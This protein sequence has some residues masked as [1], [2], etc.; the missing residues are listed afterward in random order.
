MDSSVNE[1]KLWE[2]GL[3]RFLAE[4]KTYGDRIEDIWFYETF[5]IPYP[6]PQVP[7]GEAQK[8]KLAC[9][10]PRQRFIE[11]LLKRHQMLA[12]TQ[13]DGGYE[14]IQP[15]EQTQYAVDEGQRELKNATDKM[16]ARIK[17]IRLE[18]LDEIQRRENA[19]ARVRAD[20]LASMTKSVWPRRK[21]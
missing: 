14:I 1:L 4:R 10:H 13:R 7:F 5:D 20:S 17:H 3:E 19:D 8:S 21:V 2:R 12:V 11:E 9:L 15:R 6:G 16:R 18:V